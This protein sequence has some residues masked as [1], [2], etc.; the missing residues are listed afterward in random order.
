[1]DQH[2]HLLAETLR[3]AVSQWPER[4]DA[5]G[6]RPQF[7]RESMADI[8]ANAVLAGRGNSGD[9]VRVVTDVAVTLWDGTASELDE[10]VFWRCAAAAS[11]VEFFS[12][13]SDGCGCS[14]QVFCPGMEQ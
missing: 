11:Y 7:V 14:R 13:Q 6:W 9:A 10:T 4:L 2:R 5:R 3:S 1:M 8:A 12:S